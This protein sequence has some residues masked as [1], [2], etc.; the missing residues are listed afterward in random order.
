MLAWRRPAGTT[1]RRPV[2]LDDLVG[3]RVPVLLALDTAPWITRS[4]ERVHVT[5]LA[6]SSLLL[7]SRPEPEHEGRVPEAALH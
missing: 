2:L 6:C 7:A 3:T 4:V 1:H 5:F